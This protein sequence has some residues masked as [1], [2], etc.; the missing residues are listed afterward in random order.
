MTSLDNTILD[1]LKQQAPDFLSGESLCRQLGITRSAVWKHIRSLRDAGYLIDSVTNRGYKL[2]KIPNIPYPAE[3]K[4]YLTTKD[5]GQTIQYLSRTDSTN[6]TARQHAEDG[7]PHGTVIIADQQMKGRGRLQRNWFSPGGTNLYLSVVLRPQLPPM[8][9]PSF[10]L[11]TGLAVKQA[12]QKFIKTR[13]VMIKWPNDILINSRKAAGILADINAEHDCIN[14]LIVGIGLNV[15]MTMT[16]APP[17]IRET[18]TS[19]KTEA[20]EEISRPVLTAV[21]LNCLEKLYNPWLNK[22]LEPFLDELQTSSFL[23]NKQVNVRNLHST[24]QGTVTGI[25]AAGEL[26]LRTDNGEVKNIAA[27]DATIS[28][29]EGKKQP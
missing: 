22:G 19:L 4:P 21:I 27:G 20:G 13:P 17:D 1:K 7:A 5:I 8:A 23:I 15:N 25:T 18:A 3:I 14:H 16:S 9:A 26:I 24:V 12:I 2:S 29:N 10:S 28:K 6:K 11:L